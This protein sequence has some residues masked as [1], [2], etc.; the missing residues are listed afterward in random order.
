MIQLHKQSI[1]T[2]KSMLLTNSSKKANPGLLV[3]VAL[4]MLLLLVMEAH[5]TGN[6]LHEWLGIGMAFIVLLHLL[7]HWK[8]I[9]HFTLRFSLPIKGRTRLLYG[10]DIFIFTAFVSTVFSGLMISNSVLPLFG[11]RMPREDFWFWLHHR[12]A[13]AAFLLLA[14]HLALHWNWIVNRIKNRIIRPVFSKG[15]LENAAPRHVSNPVASNRTGG[16]STFEW[17]LP[18]SF[19]LVLAFLI[20][21]VWYA[22]NA[23]G[24]TDAGMH[25]EQYVAGY[26][27]DPQRLNTGFMP[28]NQN[29]NRHGQ[30]HHDRAGGSIQELLSGM[31]VNLGI[32][33]GFT[34][35]VYAIER[36]NRFVVGIS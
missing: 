11:V 13:D 12:S 26:G 27:A 6:S 15:P 20:S 5:A 10:L 19:I 1:Q 18:P 3:D 36:S 8:W 31:A 29:R 23:F 16:K 7:L 35:A 30:R 28:R 24:L 22:V 33:A 17:M 4:L 14:L 32:L 34:I 21:S 2:L 9:L 25:K